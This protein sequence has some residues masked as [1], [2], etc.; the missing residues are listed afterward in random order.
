MHSRAGAD[1]GRLH[2]GEVMLSQAI[3]R[4]ERYPSI[5]AKIRQQAEMFGMRMIGTGIYLQGPAASQ[6]MRLEMK[7]QV[8]DE[9]TSLQQICDG[10]N[11]WILRRLGQ[12]ASLGRVEV[13]PVLDN[14][15]RWTAEVGQGTAT[16][17]TGPAGIGLGGLPR[18][19]R[20]LNHSFQFADPVPTQMMTMPVFEMHGVWRPE[21]LNRLLPGKA[22]GAN[23]IADLSKLPES[24][25]D[26]VI[27]LLGREDLFPYR[28]EYRR[29]DPADV[30]GETASSRVLL[31][32]ELFEVRANEAIERRLFEYQPG[33][34][35]IAELT[36][37]YVEIMRMR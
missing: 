35:P 7:L 27:V 19:L 22:I 34:L 26:E 16:A 32:M 37:Q 14:Q 2:A 9:V 8:E 24:V 25:P 15:R 36:P 5:T 21:A 30:D 11:L 31:I 10:T 28:V 3:D 33:E 18:L 20:S 29:H 13:A 12:Q 23:G 6:C 4:I 17:A 1:V